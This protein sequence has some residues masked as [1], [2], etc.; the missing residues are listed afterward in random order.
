MTATI[1]YLGIARG[2]GLA[3]PPTVSDSTTGLE[4]EVT[5]IVDDGNGVVLSRA[6]ALAGLEA[7]RGRLAVCDW[8][9]P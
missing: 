1:K 2:V 9:I 5:L 6:E 3:A 7:I 4:I 8:P